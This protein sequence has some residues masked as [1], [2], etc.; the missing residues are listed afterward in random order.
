MTTKIHMCAALMLS[1]GMVSVA[2]ADELILTQ[3][4]K[5]GSFAIALDYV[6]DGKSAA[7]DFRI[8]IPGGEAA[9]VDLSKCAVSLPKSHAGA[10]NFAKG[11]VIGIVYNDTNEPFPAGVHKLGVIYVSTSAEGAAKVARFDAVD[12][13][14]ERLESKVRETSAK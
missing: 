4:K 5:G 12:A 10:C 1:A 13:R 6:S 8:D 11:Q 9:K 14:G 7:F 3:E 2:N